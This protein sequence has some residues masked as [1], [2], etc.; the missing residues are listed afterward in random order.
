MLGIRVNLF[1]LNGYLVIIPLINETCIFFSLLKVLL[2]YKL[3][4]SQL[5]IVSTI[6]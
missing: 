5:L 2:F 3:S 6:Q 4:Y 1:K